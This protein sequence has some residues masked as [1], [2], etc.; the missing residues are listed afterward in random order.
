MKQIITKRIFNKSSFITGHPYCL[1]TKSEKHIFALF[2]NMPN[3]ST[4]SFVTLKKVNQ[5]PITSDCTITI[6]DIDNGSISIQ[7]MLISPNEDDELGE[8][9][10]EEIDDIN[11]YS[12]PET[13]TT[14]TD[15]IIYN[16]DD[17]S[18]V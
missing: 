2:C 17:L 10:L 12:E 9:Y 11:T 5:L 6:E 15:D 18:E 13:D 16:F 4:L 3:D 8:E 1:T 7:P 14:S